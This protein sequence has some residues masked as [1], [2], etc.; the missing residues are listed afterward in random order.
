[1]TNNCTTAFELLKDAYTQIPDLSSVEAQR[2]KVILDKLERFNI[3]EYY[4]TEDL[5][6]AEIKEKD[7]ISM[8]DFIH[9]RWYDCHD[10]RNRIEQEGLLYFYD[11]WIEVPTSFKTL[12]DFT[13]SYE[14][15]C[16]KCDESENNS[17]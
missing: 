1:M 14:C 10:L 15:W 5:S 7:K 17:E 9:S 6:E 16:G 4:N 8:R 13:Y 2:L 12:A 11:C 3:G